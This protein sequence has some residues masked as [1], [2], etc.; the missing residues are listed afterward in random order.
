MAFQAAN[1]SIP[2]LVLF[3]VKASGERHCTLS[4][5]VDAKCTLDTVYHYRNVEKVILKYNSP[6]PIVAIV[7]M[8]Q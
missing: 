2:E 6:G 7:Y 4:E 5:T 1:N 3:W 8:H